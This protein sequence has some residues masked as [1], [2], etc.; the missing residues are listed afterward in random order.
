M[1]I[2]GIYLLY[3]LLQAFGS[4][5]V[6]LYLVA[7][8]LRQPAYF[9]SLKQRCG[10]LPASFRQTVPGA[11]WLHAVSVGEAVASVELIR[12]LRARLPRSPVFVSVSTLAGFEAANRKL[13]G[14]ASVFYAPLDYVFAV[15]RVLRA[16]RPSLVMVMETEIWP[17]LFR[18]AKRTGVALMLIN[19]AHFRSRHG[20][21]SRAAL[22]L[23]ARAFAG[24]SDPGPE[25]RDAP[26]LGPD[27][28]VAG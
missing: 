11:I 28:R 10:F 9:K 12:Q 1:K 22:V 21:L 8:C 4:P 14:Q 17:N 13:D 2:K 23:R 20:T 25:R 18:E 5:A 7:R 27:R 26:A 24:G 16:L 6:V 3:R 15:R 19:G